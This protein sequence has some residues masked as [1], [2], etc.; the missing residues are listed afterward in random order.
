MLRA[1][2]SSAQNDISTPLTRFL[3]VPRVSR[4]SHLLQWT[5]IDLVIYGAR[6]VLYSHNPDWLDKAE[7]V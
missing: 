5:E 6:K 7:S 1:P 2:G 3:V 4:E